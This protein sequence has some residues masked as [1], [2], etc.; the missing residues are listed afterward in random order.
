[1]VEASEAPK[2]IPIQALFGSTRRGKYDLVEGAL[3]QRW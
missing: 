3:M 1:M 2:S